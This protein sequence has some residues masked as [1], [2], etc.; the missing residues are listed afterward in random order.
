MPFYVACQ[1]GLRAYLA[2]NILR[3]AGYKNVYNLSGGYATYK[4]F[5]HRV[6]EDKIISINREGNDMQNAVIS[7]KTDREID[8]AGLQCPGPLMA[9]YKALNDMKEGETLC[10]TATDGGFVKDVESWCQTNGHTLLE[11]KAK[12]A[13]I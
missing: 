9:T 13:N 1:A 5:K 4:T 11:L 10:V 2:V 6:G 8:V 7:E 12:K 3:G